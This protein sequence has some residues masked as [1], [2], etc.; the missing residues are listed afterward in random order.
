MSIETFLLWVFVGLVAGWLADAVVL[1]GVLGVLPDIALG[2]VSTFLGSLLFP[3]LSPSRTPA[4]VG[5][6]F[7]VGVLLLVLLKQA[8]RLR[9]TG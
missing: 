2:I 7:V 5:I 4:A 8:R 1:D 6:G 3:A 9:K